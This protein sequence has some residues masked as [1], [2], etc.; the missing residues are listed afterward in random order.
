M[1]EKPVTLI[2]ST[3]VQSHKHEAKTTLD[4][5]TRESVNAQAHL[6]DACLASGENVF[7]QT[8]TTDI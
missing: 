2:D 3:S 5:T 1:E 6:E 8:T 4:E 7:L